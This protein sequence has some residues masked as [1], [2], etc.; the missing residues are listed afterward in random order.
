MSL[1]LE[2]VTPDAQ[3]YNKTVDSVALPTEM[4]EIGILPGH[5]PLLASL[6]AG[7]VIAESEGKQEFLAVDAG[8][9][10]VFGDKVSILTEQA[11]NIENTNFDQI[12][13]AKKRA[14]EALADAERR[15]IDPAEIEKLESIARFEM[16]KELIKKKRG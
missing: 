3:V 7:E 6:E 16:L 4:G 2:I 14:Q 12:E 8:F 13:D 11:I 10:Q 9:A 5:I 15:G 1:I